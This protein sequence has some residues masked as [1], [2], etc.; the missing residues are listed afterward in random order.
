MGVSS[1]RL[2]IILAA[3]EPVLVVAA[4]LDSTDYAIAD[5]ASRMEQGDA[6][7][8]SENPSA[9]LTCFPSSRAPRDEI[10][11]SVDVH[12]AEKR[13]SPVAIEYR[14]RPNADPWSSWAPISPNKEF[15]TPKAAENLHRES[16]NRLRTA[17]GGRPR[18]ACP[19]DYSDYICV[20]QFLMEVKSTLQSW[21][22]GGLVEMTGAHIY[23]NYLSHITREES[24][25]Q[26]AEQYNQVRRVSPRLTSKR[27]SRRRGSAAMPLTTSF[28]SATV[29]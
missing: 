5:D 13:S 29:C 24:R 1:L 3:I 27:S 17:G 19:G 22:A 6:A 7:S 4:G 12:G 15:S 9:N 14:I 26:V 18:A 2:R 21:N 11:C 23:P 28:R 20:E 25:D 8:R 10:T 16:R